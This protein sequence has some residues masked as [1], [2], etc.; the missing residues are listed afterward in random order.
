VTDRLGVPAKTM[1]MV[2]TVGCF[3]TGAF[4]FTVRWLNLQP[5]TQIRPV[6]D[7]SLNLWEEDLV[8]FEAV[9]KEEDTANYGP[10]FSDKQAKSKTPTWQLSTAWLEKSGQL[11]CSQYWPAS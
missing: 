7:R 2:D 9:K 1:A 10:C 5:R 4:V 8:H 3:R 11:C 6:S